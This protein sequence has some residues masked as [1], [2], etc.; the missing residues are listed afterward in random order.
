MVIPGKQF[1]QRLKRSDLDEDVALQ[2][3]RLAKI[4]TIDNYDLEQRRPI[5]WT[6]SDA[7]DDTDDGARVYVETNS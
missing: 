5:L 2:N 3:A 6:P 1:F 7:S 4:L